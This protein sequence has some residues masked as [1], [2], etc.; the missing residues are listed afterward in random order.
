MLM[1]SSDGRAIEFNDHVVDLPCAQGHHHS[2]HERP[3]GTF[4][5]SMSAFTVVN[6][7]STIS[8]PLR[9]RNGVPL[10]KGETVAR[11]PEADGILI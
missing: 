3:D 10:S 2:E 4:A 11:S 7:C 6:A 8:T 9:Q 5:G 1:G